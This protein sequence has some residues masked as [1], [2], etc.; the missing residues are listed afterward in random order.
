MNKIVLL[1]KSNNADALKLSFTL[2]KERFPGVNDYEFV[3][4]NRR[5]DETIVP[6]GLSNNIKISTVYNPSQLK[7]V[8]KDSI[9]ISVSGLPQEDFALLIP[10]LIRLNELSIFSL[11]RD[12]EGRSIMLNLVEEGTP[13]YRFR[14]KISMRA[15]LMKGILFIIAGGFIINIAMPI[16][17]DLGNPTLVLY[18]N[19][20]GL[21]LSASGLIKSVI[22]KSA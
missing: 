20:V 11:T 21:F 15:K 12:S 9:A 10:I 2:L 7:N 5:K 19:Y 1:I 16:L 8:L 13:L 3:F 6:S 4:Y 17:P 22:P 14:K 18:N